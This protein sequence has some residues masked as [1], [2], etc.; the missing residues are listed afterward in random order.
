MEVTNLQKIDLQNADIY[1][2]QDFLSYGEAFALFNQL[3][4][5]P[6]VGSEINIKVLAN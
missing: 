6:S 2:V 4:V 5:L 3:V 1:M